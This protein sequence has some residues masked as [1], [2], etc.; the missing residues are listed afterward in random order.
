MRRMTAR[1]AA[2]ICAGAAI[3]GAQ[4]TRGSIAGR[5]VDSSGAVVPAATVTA[6]NLSTNVKLRAVSNHEGAY[7]ILFVLP[8]VYSVTA[9]VTGFKT[10]RQENVEIRIHER[11]QVDFPLEVGSLSEEVQVVA[12]APQLQTAN[13]NLGQVVDT[14]R[15]SELPVAYGSPYSLLFLLPGVADIGQTRQENT[16]TSM[17][18]AGSNMSFNGAPRGSTG[19]TIDGSENKQDAHPVGAGTQVQGGPANSP[20]A[21][22]VHE[23]KLESAFDASVGFSAGSVVNLTLKTGTNLPHGTA[24][25]FFRNPDWNANTFFANRNGQP[26]ANFSHKRW[27]TSLLGPVYIPK[28]YNGRD[29]TF[30]AY[31]YEGL[32]SSSSDGPF[33][34]T[35]PTPQNAAGDFSNLLALDAS[36][37]IYDPATIAP[38]A[39]GRFSALPFARNIIPANRISPIATKILEHFPKPNAPGRSDGVNN[40]VNTATAYPDVYFNHTARV[41]HNIDEK[42]RLYGRASF[43]RRPVGPYRPYWN[44]IAVGEVAKYATSQ[45]TIDDVYVLRPTVVLNFRYGYNRSTG[46][47]TPPRVGYDLSQLGFPAATLSQLTAVTSMFPRI[48]IGGLSTLGNE[49]YDRVTQDVHSLFAGLNKQHANH[50]LKAGVDF[51]GYR[52]TQSRFGEASGNFSFASNYTRGPLDNSPTSPSGIGQGLASLLLGVPSSG[53]INR[54]D[55]QASQS[56]AWG[57]Y[58]HDNWRATPNLSLDI[59]LRWE[60]EVPLTERFN[61]SVRGFDPNAAQAVESAAKASYNAAPDTA[62][63]ADQFRVRGGLLFAGVGGVSRGL[64]QGSARGFAP[65]FGFAYQ[66][67]RK[68]V[69]RGG[70]GIYPIMRG[71]AGQH[72]AIESGFDQDTQVVPT[73]NGGQTFVA[74]LANPFPNGLLTAP[75]AALG[76]ATFLGRGV[77]FFNPAGRIPYTMQMG[78]NTQT[79]LPGQFLLEVGY[80]GTKSIK[81]MLDR[82]LN[83]L[84]NQYL[85]TL[86]VRD[87][88]T[89][90]YLS[91][92]VAN[93]FSGLLPGTNLNGTTV[94]RSQLLRPYPQ[95]TSVTMTDYQGWAWYNSLQVRLERRLRQGLTL[96]AGYNFSKNIV[97]A[98][99]QN[100][101]DPLPT[102]VISEID[103]PHQFSVSG[104]WELPFGKHRR[105]LSSRSRLAD[106]FVGGWQ[107]SGVVQMNSGFPLS[108]GDVIFTGDLKNIALPKSERSI[109]RWF[110]TDAGFNRITAQQFG[111]HLRTFPLRLSGVRSSGFASTDISLLKNFALHERHRFQFRA[112]FYNAFNHPTAFGAPNTTPTSTAF[113]VVTGM[114]GLPREI[115]LGIKYVF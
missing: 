33:T 18:V 1:I 69:L 9:S 35:V 30:F 86:P 93:P 22:I 54:N 50:N 75:G 105:W 102:K 79:M 88:R 42:Q 65:R 85:S 70:F 19:W 53:L 14:R 90:D 104:L 6:T 37:Q 61:R 84:P 26:K 5:V 16:P 45:F 67:L 25:G 56:T 57:L 96:L 36:Y 78:L 73:L 13:A 48:A 113:G 46:G 100:A 34:G 59:G 97:A 21:D 51:R 82:D 24:Y 4:E 63:A 71:V 98:S 12:E 112:E 103:R 91:A 87:Q 52:V 3:A 95:F 28:L 66:G 31:A 111:S 62:L 41:D 77:N 106:T 20:P 72:F 7:Q 17:D 44:D 108:F 49:A 47:H 83:A 39:Q 89:I 32:H 114:Q 2:L 58:L 40:F 38:A 109:D 107:V 115:Q 11:V 8:G 60:Y 29:R 55:T 94:G 10:A 99:R 92:N 43:V 101:G 64:W 110:N 23:F 74:T 15:I 27:G 76:A 81:L 80:V 68:V